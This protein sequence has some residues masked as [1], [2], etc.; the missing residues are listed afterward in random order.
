[1]SEMDPMETVGDWVQV[2]PWKTRYVMLVLVTPVG[3]W[4]ANSVAGKRELLGRGDEGV[5]VV[6][7][8]GRWA[9]T[10]RMVSADD[11]DGVRA[12]LA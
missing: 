2:A 6:S 5:L 7:W 11:V 12:A 3:W 1:M 8:A 10:S 9:V 4:E